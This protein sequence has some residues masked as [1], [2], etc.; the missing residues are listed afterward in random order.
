MDVYIY[1]IDKNEDKFKGRNKIVTV[2]NELNT[3]RRKRIENRKY[4]SMYYISIR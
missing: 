4:I 1:I 2:L 3:E